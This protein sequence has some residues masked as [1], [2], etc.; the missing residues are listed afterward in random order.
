MSETTARV[1][2]GVGRGQG[3]A[4]RGG[5]GELKT[6]ATGPGCVGSSAGF[7][8]KTEFLINILVTNNR[9]PFVSEKSNRL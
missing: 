6:P 8:P 3:R 4:G 2:V 5:V 9:R 7:V 1:W